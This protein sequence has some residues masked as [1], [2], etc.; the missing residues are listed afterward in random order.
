MESPEN[1]KI[2]GTIFS[3]K[4]TPRHICGE[5]HTLKGYTHPSVHCSTISNSQD[6][7]ASTDEWIKRI[8]YIHTME[9]H[10]PI[11]RNEIIPCAATWVDLEIVRLSEVRER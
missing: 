6:V 1:T 11:K 10:S 4:I 7:E 5:N 9:Y 3:I 8:W 2:R